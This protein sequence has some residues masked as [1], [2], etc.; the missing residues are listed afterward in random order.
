MKLSAKSV[1]RGRVA[2]AT[3]WDATGNGTPRASVAA[4]VL[5]GTSLLLPTAGA[6]AQPTDAVE[7]NSGMAFSAPLP[8]GESVAVYPA[9]RNRADDDIRNHVYLYLPPL[10]PERDANGQV[11][12]MTTHSEGVRVRF[13]GASPS[14]TDGLHEWLAAQDPA[15]LLPA[16]RSGSRS[17]RPLPYDTIRILDA[18]LE[19]DSR[20]EAVYGSTDVT[21]VPL[22]EWIPFVFTRRDGAGESPADFIDRLNDPAR[23]PSF[24]AEV[25]YGG[26]IQVMDSLILNA[27]VLTTTDFL[28]ELEGNGSR[29]LVTRDQARDLVS[30]YLTEVSQRT[31]QESSVGPENL[32]AGW[33]DSG[34]FQ[35]VR[36]SGEDFWNNDAENLRR[37]GFSGDDLSPDRHREMREKTAREL[38]D[39]SDNKL[40]QATSN[41]W[42]RGASS[43]SA[44]GTFFGIGANVAV[45]NPGGGGGDAERVDKSEFRKHLESDNSS[46]EWTGEI[47]VPK[48]VE[49]Y[50]VDAGRLDTET[51]LAS[52][53]VRS[54]R[55]TAS[56]G[57]TIDNRS[58]PPEP[59]PGVIEEMREALDNLRK[60][61]AM[62]RDLQANFRE[63]RQEIQQATERSEAEDLRLAEQMADLER[64]QGE[65]G[66][67]LE[68]L[69]VD[70]G[71][72]EER[73]HHTVYEAETAGIVVAAIDT[74][75]STNNR[76][77]GIV[78][79]VAPVPENLTVP[80]NR[81]YRRG[82]GS[83]QYAGVEN[84]YL[85]YDDIAMPVGQGEYWTIRSG[86]GD[87][88]QDGSAEFRFCPLTLKQS[89]G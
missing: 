22:Q 40:S 88:F 85:I 77:L 70:V 56:L 46:F 16:P 69:T 10:T 86:Y 9:A 8:T 78:G 4:A 72:C 50:Q 55:A 31:Y 36:M 43:I 26:R 2:A 65:Q 28:V 19:P 41:Y 74:G 20:W 52:I 44:G 11:P 67:Q 21:P 81:Q 33:L 15:T 37:A 89:G 3:R 27:S 5:L 59:R 13:R 53:S 49:L 57:Y 25:S 35:R 73:R 17:V 1:R 12:A 7:P 80:I 23:L 79:Y 48:N 45:T 63:L 24:S 76:R 82:G 87:P 29:E 18:D 61:E 58:R 84:S 14:I 64:R 62:V 38:L 71:P 32:N 47:I 30:K 6:Q 42:T 60:E 66:V 51:R 39:E 75:Q 34:L 83:V 68:G 54:T